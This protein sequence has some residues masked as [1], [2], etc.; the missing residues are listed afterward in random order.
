MFKTHSSN[1]FK[2]L[3]A[4]L[5]TCFGACFFVN[6]IALTVASHIINYGDE[7]KP[8]LFAFFGAL[9]GSNIS[10]FS[11]ALTLLPAC[12]ISKYVF[13]QSLPLTVLFSCLPGVFLYWYEPGYLSLI[14]AA[15]TVLAGALFF[16]T[17]GKLNNVD[18]EGN[19][20]HDLTQAIICTP[21]IAALAVFIYLQLFV[22]TTLDPEVNDWIARANENV[23]L[24]NNGNVYRYGLDAEEGKDPYEEGLARVR[25]TETKKRLNEKIAVIYKSN[26]S[27]A[28]LNLS[29]E[30]TCS[31]RKFECLEFSLS[32]ADTLPGVLSKNQLLLRRYQEL[33]NY[34][35]FYPIYSTHSDYPQIGF[36]EII[37]ARRLFVF[38]VI[39]SAANGRFEEAVSN[40]AEDI[41][42][43]RRV[44]KNETSLISHVINIVQ[45]QEDF[46]LLSFI[47][48]NAPK[49]FNGAKI[50]PIPL[51]DASETGKHNRVLE[52]EFS[53]SVIA[54]MEDISPA[55]DPGNLVSRLIFKPNRTINILFED[56]KKIRGPYLLY[57]K[58]GDK[59]LGYL[60]KSDLTIGIDYRNFFGSVLYSTH[61]P[62]FIDLASQYYDL[63]AQIQ[64]LNFQLQNYQL[65]KNDEDY[66]SNVAKKVGPSINLG[67]KA[68][69]DRNLVC[70]D[71][72]ESKKKNINGLCI[73]LKSDNPVN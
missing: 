38:N 11:L 43:I 1:Y 32:Q 70:F 25:K 4:L 50:E 71:K 9:I 40:V 2:Y 35:N 44:M 17:I 66:Y 18:E 62:R 54:I 34:Q 49:T 57:E 63:N 19:H 69:K 26:F 5:R 8:L 22:D 16:R 60:N 29:E 14:W 39:H 48:G 7:V 41:A 55:Y 33:S 27:E 45:L 73:W 30:M 42:F 21:L 72:K 56:Y 59:E 64:L 23:T 47:L 68:Y 3:L 6:F 67:L 36:D 52:R 58:E 28:S 46:Y 13:R 20:T 31:L 53:K 12:S 51:I 10:F 65:I 24:D 61:I 37:A 15:T